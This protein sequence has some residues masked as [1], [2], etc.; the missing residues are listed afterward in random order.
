MKLKIAAVIAAAT[1]ALGACSAADQKGEPTTT[2]GGTVT[3]MT[4]DSFVL[5]K[6]LITAWEK[7][8]GFTLKTTS[9][10]DGGTVLNQ[11]ILTKGAP[12]VDAFFG[13]DNF[14]SGRALQEGIAEPFETAAL[15]DS[16]KQY[17]EESLIPIDMGDVCINVDTV[18]FEE[19]GLAVPT[20][21]DQLTDPAYKDLLVVTNPATSSPG[22]AFLVA[23]ATVK[24]D[25]WEAYWTDLIKNGAKVS[26]SWSDAYYTDFSG[27]DGAGAYPLVLSYASSP[28]ESAGD[29]SI[30]ES[31]CIRQIEYAGVVKGAKNAEGAKE[32]IQFLLSDEVQK[33]FPTSMYMYPINPSI[34]LPDEWAKYTKLMD[35]PIMPVSDTV[36]ANR[37][38]WIKDWTALYEANAGK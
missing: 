5:P 37:E 9:P 19:K 13:L 25:S 33:A 31:S 3:V 7:K 16:A 8:S 32:F 14:S 24:P 29:T 1:L 34:Q 12:K 10:G 18:W 20:T 30:M 23:T 38:G 27:A 11:L 21:L 35:K 4:H 6:D 36:V 26:D 2:S 28:A 22:F 15:P 17:A